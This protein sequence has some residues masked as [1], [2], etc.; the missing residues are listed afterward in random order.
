MLQT[1]LENKGMTT[2]SLSHK[3]GVPYSTLSDIVSG[4][5]DI[6]SAS[7]SV[8]YKLSTTLHIS[9]EDLYLGKQEKRV[10]Y[11][12][13]SGRNVFIYAGHK[14]FS[15]Q[16]PKNLIGFRN[17]TANRSN[18]LYVDTYFINEN[19]RIFVEEDYIDLA[20]I[21]AGYEDLLHNPYEVV[22]GRPGDSKTQYLIDNSLF[23]SDNLAVSRND[24]GTDDIVVEVVN[25]KRNSDKMLLRVKDYAV[26]FSNMSNKMEKRAVAAVQRNY[27]LLI[28]E[29]EERKRA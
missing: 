4:K 3:S 17:I 9:M 15:Y 20:D 28:E 11:L 25:L 10:L 8:L 2:Y 6:Q 12:Y 29:L 21:M 5:T 16:G 18:V 23:V 1:I 19:G 14:Q 26:L 27:D 7:A 13:N 22:I 24:N